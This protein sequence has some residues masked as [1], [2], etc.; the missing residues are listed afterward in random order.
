MLI[1]TKTM[2]SNGKIILG[3]NINDFGYKKKHCQKINYFSDMSNSVIF[4]GH[5]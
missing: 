2:Y 3:H 1:A 4:G 5:F